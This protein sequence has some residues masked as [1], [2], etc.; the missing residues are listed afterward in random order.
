M[1]D[2]A[3][4]YVDIRET[5]AH[6]NR[7]LKGNDL[8]DANGN[9]AQIREAR[10]GSSS[11]QGEEELVV[12]GPNFLHGSWTLAWRRAKELYCVLDAYRGNAI[13]EGEE[14]ENLLP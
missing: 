6:R 9:L 14:A 11:G 8:S 13:D 5:K 10:K 3:T 1:G 2:G 7:K 4:D 12:V